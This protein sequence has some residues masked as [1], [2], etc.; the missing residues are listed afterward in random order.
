MITIKEDCLICMYCMK[1]SDA[2]FINIE[3]IIQFKQINANNKISNKCWKMKGRVA[4]WVLYCLI[5][6]DPEYWHGRTSEVVE[7]IFLVTLVSNKI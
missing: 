2:K 3:E 5:H 4:Y 1:S 6:Q 7:L